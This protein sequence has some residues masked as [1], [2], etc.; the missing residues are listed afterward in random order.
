MQINISDVFKKSFNDV[1]TISEEHDDFFK[2][3]S[4][5]MS[6]L[7]NLI[8]Y[9]RI[10]SMCFASNLN[11]CL[12]KQFIKNPVQKILETTSVEFKPNSQTSYTYKNTSSSAC[13]LGDIDNDKKQCVDHSNEEQCWLSFDI[14]FTIPIQKNLPENVLNRLQKLFERYTDGIDVICLDLICPTT[15]CKM[16]SQS[17]NNNIWYSIKY[18]NENDSQYLEVRMTN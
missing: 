5:P 7:K 8:E 2:P 11:D 10:L 15:H 13:D 18:K 9:W 12:R 3:S 1:L 17:F 16:E 4:H 6:E 14:T